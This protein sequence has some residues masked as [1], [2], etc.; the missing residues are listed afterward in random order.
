MKTNSIQCVYLITRWAYVTSKTLTLIHSRSLNAIHL[1]ICI[2][3]ELTR[4]LKS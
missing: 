2:N 4:P 3:I 1:K